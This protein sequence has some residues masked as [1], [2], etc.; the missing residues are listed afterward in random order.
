MAFDPNLNNATRIA[1]R[2]MIDLISARKGLKREDAYTLCSL[3]ADVR[4]TQMV[5]EQNG[6]HI[7]LPRRYL[8]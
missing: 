7:M 1:L 6:I 3:A 2:Q 8:A 4:V 5:N